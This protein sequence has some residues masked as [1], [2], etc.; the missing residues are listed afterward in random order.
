MTTDGGGW[1]LVMKI[2]AS[3]QDQ[4]LTTDQNS[5]GLAQ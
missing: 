2:N 3:S 1:T 5:T 4:Y